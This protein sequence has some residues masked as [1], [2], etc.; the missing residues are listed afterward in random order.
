MSE[1]MLVLK[2]LAERSEAAEAGRATEEADGIG[3]AF[4]IAEVAFSLALTR[5]RMEAS[6]MRTLH[7]Q[8]RGKAGDR[9]DAVP[10]A[11]HATS[12]SAARVWMDS[13]WSGHVQCNAERG[14][15]S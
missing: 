3:D 12:G 8:S 13:G 9:C 15:V 14:R 11:R 4:V 6:T 5:L 10:A 2:W 1:A 7:A